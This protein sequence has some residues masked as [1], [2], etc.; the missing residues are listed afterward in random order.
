MVALICGTSIV[1][2]A[3]L[4]IWLENRIPYVP[5]QRILRRGFW[6]DLIFYT[7]LQSY[8]LGLLINMIIAAMMPF[9]G[10]VSSGY[11]EVWP[12]WLQVVFFLVTHDLYIYWMHR[13]QHRSRI[14]WRL[15]EAHHST[16]DVDWLSGS[17][18]HAFEI[19]I[20]QTVEFAPMALLGASPETAV[21]KGSI[22]AIWGMYIHANIDVRAGW[23]QYII[24]GPGMHRWHHSDDAH[25]GSFNYATKFAIWDWI[26]GT[27]KYPRT[28]KPG[29]YGIREISFPVDYFRQFLFVFRPFRTDPVLQRELNPD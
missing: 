27:A 22:S 26:F 8:L 1:V 3:A 12:L 25:D 18:S 9:H 24:N 10:A 4:F 17:R 21:I 23:L 11:L 16:D 2:A 13:M 28:L 5:A 29:G 7:L 20:N 15:H 14:L 19:L 6:N